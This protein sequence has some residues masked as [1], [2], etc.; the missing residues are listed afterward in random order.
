MLQFKLNQKFYLEICEN[1]DKPEMHCN[2]KCHLK[3][4]ILEHEK[5]ESTNEKVLSEKEPLLYL[6]TTKN[7]YKPPFYQKPRLLK[8]LSP[9]FH[10]PIF[11]FDIF[12]PPRKLNL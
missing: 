4:Q 12:H 7:Y 9:Q 2:G 8:L 10:P 3:K 1:K 11:Y 6:F 5:K